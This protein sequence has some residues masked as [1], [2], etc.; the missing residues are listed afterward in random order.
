MK[1]IAFLVT[2]GFEDIEAKVPYDRLKELGYKTVIVGT[3][4]DREITGKRGKVKYKT[5]LSIESVGKEDFDA[6]VIPGGY[7]PDRLRLNKEVVDF[8]REFYTTNKPIA[9]ICHGP[10]LLI[11]ARVLSG[12]QVTG[13]ES[14][15]VD[16]ENAGADYLDNSVVIDRNII[17]SRKPKDIPQFIDAIIS[18]IDKSEKEE[19]TA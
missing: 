3:A 13:W 8:V 6:I 12:H 5:E 9:V 15:A 10:Q 1:K 19:L 14:I 16:I 11:T 4:E 17:S 7:S 2:D 18:E